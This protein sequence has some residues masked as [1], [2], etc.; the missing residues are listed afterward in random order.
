MDDKGVIMYWWKGKIV[1]KKWL[2]M[3][4]LLLLLLIRYRYRYRLLGID[5][6]SLIKAH[7]CLASLSFA[8]RPPY[9]LLHSSPSSV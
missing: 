7:D 3:K 5:Y 4:T 6:S 2:T 8:V 1:Q 9:Q